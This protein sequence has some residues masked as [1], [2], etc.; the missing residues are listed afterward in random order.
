MELDMVLR[1]ALL[2]FSKG[3]TRAH[4][5]RVDPGSLLDFGFHAP[6]LETEHHHRTP[7]ICQFIDQ[8]RGL[9]FCQRNAHTRH[10]T[11]PRPR[12]RAPNDN[13][14]ASPR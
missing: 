8:I 1:L 7:I 11:V 6:S 13:D 9:F 2:L 14:H 10:R 5:Q 12:V 4:T 3:T